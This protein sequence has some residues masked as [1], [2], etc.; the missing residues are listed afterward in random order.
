[1]IHK[2]RFNS[3]LFL[4]AFFGALVLGLTSGT[5]AAGGFVFLILMIWFFMMLA[6]F[7]KLALTGKPLLYNTRVSATKDGGYTEH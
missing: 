3:I 6:S 7:V 4:L 5:E 1:M 2:A